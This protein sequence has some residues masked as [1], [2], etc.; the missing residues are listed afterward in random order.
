MALNLNKIKNMLPDLN[1]ALTNYISDPKNPMYNFILGQIYENSGHTAAAASFFIRTT[2]FGYDDLLTYESL[3]RLAG[4]FERQGSRI[5]TVKGILLR[6]IALLPK[7]PEAYYQLG[8]IYE[9]VK[10]WQECYAICTIGIELVDE[11]PKEKLKTNVG[12][13]G[14]TGLI[15]EKAVAAWWIGLYD[16]S[17]TTFRKLEKDPTVTEHHRIISRNNIINLGGTLWKNPITYNDSLYEHLKIKFPGSANIDKNYSQCYQ[18]IF[19]LT[20]LNGKRE[21]KFLEIGCAG[22]YFGNNTALLEKS[23]GWTGISIDYDQNAINEFSAERVAKT[24]CADATKIDYVDLLKDEKDFDY[25][26]LDCDPAL[27][28]Y[29]TLLR[30]PFEYHK[31]AVITFEHDNYVDE[32][33]LVRDKSRKYLLSH[34][35]ELIVANI[36]P[37][38]YNSY[39]DWYVHPDLVSKDIIEKM[40]DLSE[41]PKRADTY[42]LKREL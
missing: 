2:E 32:N 7:R 39:E 31:F 11:N 26:Q 30:I 10:E 4:C 24:I 12:Y 19:V 1:T 36:A 6:A 8:K 33:S 35:Y 18:D 16:E 41:K 25:L 40:K 27:I 28:T 38:D 14:K 22:P 20:M 42:M 34:G 15:F 29:K 13:N 5:F 37:D 17:I 23:F 21:G 3:L 9:M